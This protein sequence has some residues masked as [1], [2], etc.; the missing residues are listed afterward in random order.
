MVIKRSASLDTPRQDRNSLLV[1]A[2]FT[3]VNQ[4]APL[5]GANLAQARHALE[6]C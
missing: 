1:S 3:L 5:D 2:G 6:V 4:E